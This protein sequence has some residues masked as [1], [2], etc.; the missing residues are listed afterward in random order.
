M[1]K[2]RMRKIIEIK[3]GSHL[4][5]TDTENSDLD[6]KGIFLP[7]KEELL[8]GNHRTNIQLTRN[9]KVGERNTK[10]DV[11][12][13]LVSLDRF[14]E[15]LTDGQTMALDMLFA[16]STHYTEEGAE[17]YA[18]KDGEIWNEIKA[19]QERFL[20]KRVSSFV[21]Y[22]RK[23]ASKYGVKGSRIAAVRDVLSLL[24]SLPQGSK[25]SNHD[26]AIKQLV[27]STKV[28]VS[29]EKLP[30]VEIIMLPSH[31]GGPPQSYLQCCGRKA[32]LSIKVIDAVKI[33]QRVFD[34]YGARAVQAETNHG[35][36]WKAL[37]HAVRVNTEAIELL[38]TGKITLPLINR[39]HILQ[40]KLGKIPYREVAVLI[41]D[42]LSN[43]EA[44]KNSS[45]LRLEPDKKWATEF[46]NRVY[47]EICGEWPLKPSKT[48]RS[49]NLFKSMVVQSRVFP[50]LKKAA[51]GIKKARWKIR[52]WFIKTNTSKI[53]RETS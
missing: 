15:L 31:K 50:Y 29:L 13:E 52:G 38:T 51:T 14:I 5:G 41:E 33:Y 3:F 43:L 10:S 53:K 48:I 21:G 1:E 17:A 44:A 28:H 20:S 36:D 30:L 26:G 9:K 4:Y 16:P 12:V 34:E 45:S 49:L 18:S 6:I 27:A 35:V 11:D 40:I 24:K 22:A 2:M 39:E 32:P 46:I 25:L 37:S 19:N 8:S 23:Q 7:S 47:A 42:G